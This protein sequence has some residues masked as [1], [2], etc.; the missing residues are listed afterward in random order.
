M[1]RVIKYIEERPV[2][3]ALALACAFGGVLAHQATAAPAGSLNSSIVPI[4]CGAK[5]SGYYALGPSARGAT[6]SMTVYRARFVGQRTVLVLSRSW[7]IPRTSRAGSKGL[8]VTT[9]RLQDGWLYMARVKLTVTT[10]TTTESATQTT[11]TV[12]IRCR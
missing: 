11:R 3:V 6:L 2:R 4:N 1:D 5:V 8:N 7:A 10:A 12:R 9:T